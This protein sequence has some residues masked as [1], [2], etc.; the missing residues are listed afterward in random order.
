MPSLK[1]QFIDYMQVHRISNTTQKAYLRWVNESV[2]ET[3]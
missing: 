3:H 1:K 2:C